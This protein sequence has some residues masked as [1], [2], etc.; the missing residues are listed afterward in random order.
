MRKSFWPRRAGFRLLVR[1]I[2]IGLQMVVHLGV[3]YCRLGRLDEMLRAFREAVGT[4]PVAVRAALRDEPLELEELR[5]LLS[6]GQIV[7]ALPEETGEPPP[8]AHVEASWALAGLGREHISGGRDE[9][10]IAGLEASVRQDVTNRLTV[11]L[12]SLAYLLC[13]WDGMALADVEGSVL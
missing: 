11:A 2:R 10:A 1:P 3:A 13:E 7:A 4:D 9:E 8:M 6:P 12:L 5:T